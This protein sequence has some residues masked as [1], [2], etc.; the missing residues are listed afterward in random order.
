MVP[1]LARLPTW[2]TE[3]VL[4]SYL[5]AALV[6][7]SAAKT[8][9]QAFILTRWSKRSNYW[10]D[11]ALVSES[12]TKM[13]NV[14]QKIGRHQ[15]VRVA[16]TQTKSGHWASRGRAFALHGCGLCPPVISAEPSAPP[17]LRHELFLMGPLFLWHSLKIQSSRWEHLVGYVQVTYAREASSWGKRTSAPCSARQDWVYHQWR[18]SPK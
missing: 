6:R 10:E 9:T 2:A 1:R 17:L 3:A 5:W 14:A 16:K 18:I 8:K 15:E 11:T 7:F 13:E 4:Y 12:I